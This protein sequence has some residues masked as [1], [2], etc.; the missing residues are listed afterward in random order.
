MLPDIRSA[1][2]ERGND[3]HNNDQHESKNASQ[4]SAHKTEQNSRVATQGLC[5]L[6]R[7]YT[8]IN[9]SSCPYELACYFYRGLCYSLIISRSALQSLIASDKTQLVPGVALN[10]H[11][12]NP[13][14][15]D[16]TDCMHAQKGVGKGI[17]QSQSWSGSPQIACLDH[18]SHRVLKTDFSLVRV[19]YSFALNPKS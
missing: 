12:L 9:L 19:E 8:S 3:A 11:L 6:S 10:N 2:K 1:R 18:T 15:L 5:C 7:H 4:H 16:K 14:K 17:G 13:G